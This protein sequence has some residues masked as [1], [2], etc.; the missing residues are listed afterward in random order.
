MSSFV[1]TEHT[2]SANAPLRQQQPDSFF[3]LILITGIHRILFNRGRTIKA[4]FYDDNK[5]N[6]IVTGKIDL[7]VKMHTTANANNDLIGN[8]ICFVLSHIDS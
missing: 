8:Q 7:C 5:L 4:T 3:P 6:L 2:P 1:V